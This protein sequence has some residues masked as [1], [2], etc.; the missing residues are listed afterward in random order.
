MLNFA[1]YQHQSIVA[2]ALMLSLLGTACNPF[3]TAQGPEIKTS[4]VC[5]FEGTELVIQ[6]IP[7][8]DNTTIT[9]ELVE[10]VA[11]IIARRLEALGIEGAAV[12]PETA[13]QVRVQL[14][15]GIDPSPAAR[16]LG[17]RG[18]LSFRL[19][20]QAADSSKLQ[21]LLAERESISE[22]DD[23][24]RQANRDAI[25]ALFEPTPLTGAQIYDASAQLNTIDQWEVLIAFDEAGA[26]A[27][28]DLTQQ[29]AGTGQAIGI[30]LDE[31]LIS[32]PV[33]D[34][35]YAETGI[36]GGEAVISGNF[37]DEAAR[38]LAIQLRSGAFPTDAEYLSV[39]QAIRDDNC[40]TDAHSAEN[41]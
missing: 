40:E 36:T 7:S 24:A 26:Q 33:I 15:L 23:A 13:D 19:Q 6:I 31:R 39:Q 29:L 11:A 12:F 20:R 17:N 27:F 10:E 32:A 16:M 41:E 1:A 34:G 9:P 4:M 2:A 18:Q 22:S 5:P 30:F 21:M 3:M 14:P 37:T 8:P 38:D 35:I 28:A 25:A